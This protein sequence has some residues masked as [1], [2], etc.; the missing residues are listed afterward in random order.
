MRCGQLGCF[1]RHLQQQ[2]QVQ[3]CLPHL[4]LCFQSLAQSG[5]QHQAEGWSFDQ[6][7]AAALRLDQVAGWLHGW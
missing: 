1:Q 7:S 3:L 6:Q 2:Q 5:L 4:P